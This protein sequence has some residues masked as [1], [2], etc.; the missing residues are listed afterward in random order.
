MTLI[1]SEKGDP[2]LLHSVIVLQMLTHR[3]ES[4][5]AGVEKD[6]KRNKISDR[7][8]TVTDFPFYIFN[9]CFVGFA[10][11]DYCF[12]WLTADGDSHKK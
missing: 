5:F 1:L 11:S 12:L 8:A 6:L 2:R 7:I 4:L 9:C 3:P 10:V